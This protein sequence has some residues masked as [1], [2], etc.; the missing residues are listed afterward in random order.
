MLTVSLVLIFTAI[1]GNVAGQI[2]EVTNSQLILNLIFGLGF[3][4]AGVI[5]GILNENELSKAIITIVISFFVIGTV[6]AINLSIFCTDLGCI[7]VALTF[8]GIPTAM[9]ET[10]IG[11]IVG[12]QLS[13]RF[14]KS[15]TQQIGSQVD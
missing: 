14:G 1:N 5:G 13:L 2:E 9:V 12:D 10:S 8:Q 11:F 3:F 4:I 7:W 6:T 15:T